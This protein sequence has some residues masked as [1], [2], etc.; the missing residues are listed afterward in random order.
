MR[1]KPAGVDNSLDEYMPVSRRNS[2]SAHPA[3][4]AKRLAQSVEHETL[5][6]MVVGSSPTLG[7]SVTST[8]DGLHDPANYGRGLEGDGQSVLQVTRRRR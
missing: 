2:I 6:L 4:G 1:W 8:P 7:A 3:A 5:N